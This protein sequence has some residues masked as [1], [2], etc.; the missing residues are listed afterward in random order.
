[1]NK[2]LSPESVEFL[3]DRMI[4]QPY[5]RPKWDTAHENEDWQEYYDLLDRVKAK[6]SVMGKKMPI[7]LK[8]CLTDDALTPVPGVGLVILI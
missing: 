8:A 7:R 4:G 3:F 6:A 5:F 1:M 2:N